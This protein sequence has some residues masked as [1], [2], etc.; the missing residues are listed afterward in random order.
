MRT[1]DPNISEGIHTVKITLQQRDYVGHIIQK[2]R[3]NCKG[4]DLLTFDFEDEEEFPNND[5][6][7]K[8]HEDADFFT[9]VLKNENGDT[10][11]CEG[12]AIEMNNMIVCIEIIDFSEDGEK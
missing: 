4:R 12:D 9:C 10:L 7:L 3:G 8:Y 5:C 11:Y 2:I 6:Q 1:Y